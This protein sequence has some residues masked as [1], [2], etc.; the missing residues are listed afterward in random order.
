MKWALAILAV[1]AAAAAAWY[2]T[3]SREG[4]T[5]EQAEAVARFGSSSTRSNLAALALKGAA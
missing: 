1:V 3:R 5:A 2:F 4:M